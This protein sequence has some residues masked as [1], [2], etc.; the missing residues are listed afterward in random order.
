MGG[1]SPPS[2][3]TEYCVGGGPPPS[4]ITCIHISYIHVSAHSLTSSS[5]ISLLHLLVHHPTHS[6]PHPSSHS[7]TSSSIISLPHLHHFTPLSPCP[8]SH[9]LSQGS[10]WQS[11]GIKAK[12]PGG[13][14]PGIKAK[15]PGGS[16]Q[17]SMNR[18]E[19]QFLAGSYSPVGCATTEPPA[20]IEKACNKEK[21]LIIPPDPRFVASEVDHLQKL[22]KN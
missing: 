18:L 19:S 7:L 15:V 21:N 17:E 14:P 2:S 20:E 16:P 12:V 1:G 5:I 6:P 9:S 4:S 13:S 10:W 3:R 22:V 11:P 8:L